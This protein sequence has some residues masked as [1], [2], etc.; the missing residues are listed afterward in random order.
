MSIVIFGWLLNVKDQ[1]T[2]VV[3]GVGQTLLYSYGNK[4]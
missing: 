3:C 4:P 1:C 2:K